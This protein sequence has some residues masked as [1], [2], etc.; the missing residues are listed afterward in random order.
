[1]STTEL[2]VEAPAGPPGLVLRHATPDDWAAVAGIVN[3]ARA[4][5]GLDE[6]Q[7]AATMAGEHPDG[8][9]FRLD[10]DLLIAEVDGRP[11]GYGIGCLV[12]REGVLVVET[13]GDVD[14]GHRR[15]GIGT[16]LHRANR[17]RLAEAAARDPRPGPRELRSY[18]MDQEPGDLA[19]LAAEGFVPIRYGFEMRRPL[20]GRLPEHPLPVG[21]ELRPV[22]PD[23]ERTIYLA[24]NE[25]FEDHWGHRAPDDADFEVRFRGPDADTSLWVVAWDGDQVAGVVMSA[26]YRAENESLGIRRAWMEHVSV[27]RAW[28]GRGLAKALCAASFR[29]LRDRG[30]DEAWLGV[31]AA[32]P[33]GALRLYEGLGFSVVRRWQALGRPLDRPAPPGWTSA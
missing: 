10:R 15:R 8:D 19:M 6:V 33:T 30:M 21:L 27:R 23:V 5:D 13:Y 11:V 17:E 28:R 9:L 14:P 4:A 18:A 16:A 7:T 12:E 26:V 32:N 22:T 1:M 3:A 29:V 31:D 20:T 25:A 24:D 2:R